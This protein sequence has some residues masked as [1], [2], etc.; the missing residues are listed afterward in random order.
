VA[1]KTWQGEVKLR[2]KKSA[3]SMKQ[4]A[5]NRRNAEGLGG[6]GRDGDPEAR[7]LAYGANGKRRNQEERRTE[8]FPKAR[9]SA[10]RMLLAARF[11][12]AEKVIKRKEKQPKEEELQERP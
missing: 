10:E 4:R 8:A 11:T 9:S 3:D 6:G 2:L 1:T 7:T 12:P 5:F